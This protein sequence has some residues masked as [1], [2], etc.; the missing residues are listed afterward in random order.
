MKN[1]F[2]EL[3]DTHKLLLIIGLYVGTFFFTLLSA[4]AEFFSL[5]CVACLAFAIIFTVFYVQY[6][7]SNT[8]QEAPIQNITAPKSY[9]LRWERRAK[10]P[11][12]K[13]LDKVKWNDCDIKLV[14]EPDN[15]Y[16]P[17]AVALYKG[18]YKLGY[19]HGQTQEMVLEYLKHKDY[20]IKTSVYWLN[21][22]NKKYKLAVR[23]AFYHKSDSL[24]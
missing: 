6:K 2:N 24:K 10:I 11:F 14:P 21:P 23:I 4:V 13:N 8:S 1:W 12:A 7:K 22:K 3:E 5:F 20:L 16:N 19:L 9:F 15:R 17:N 18:E